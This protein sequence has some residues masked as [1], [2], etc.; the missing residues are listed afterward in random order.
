VVEAGDTVARGETVPAAIAVLELVGGARQWSNGTYA[1]SCEAYIRPSD[2]LHLYQGAT[3]SGT[4]RIAPAG[5][6]VSAYCDMDNDNGGWTKILQYAS[7]A[8]TPSAAAFG[9]I[10]QASVDAAAKLSDSTINA[11]RALSGTPT[12]RLQG[13]DPGNSGIKAYI[14]SA[15]AFSDPSIG[16]G[17]ATGNLQWCVATGL[18]GSFSSTN[19][20]YLDT[21]AWGGGND[22]SRYFAD[23]P[24]DTINCYT[25]VG[26][27]APGTRCVS[28]GSTCGGHA[29]R[30]AF[31]MWIRP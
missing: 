12:Y 20:T 22:C 29:R 4:Y 3:G 10:D 13:T 24:A 7:A 18:C 14:R 21:T 23:Y 6:P 26:I 25:G 5:S 16:W 27:G 28:A 17:F 1:T 8:Y 30:T 19:A 11:I 15:Q 2:A 31:T 9:T